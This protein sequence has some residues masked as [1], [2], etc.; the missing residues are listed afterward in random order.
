MK[1]F[2]NKKVKSSNPDIN[3]GLLNADAGLG[4]QPQNRPMSQPSPTPT[5][6]SKDIER[7]KVVPK[8]LHKD[9]KE[10]YD[11]DFC[12]VLPNPEDDQFKEKPIDPKYQPP[13]EILRRLHTAGLETY[14]YYSGDWDEIFIKIRAPLDV[15]RS[16]AKNMELKMLLDS[17]YIK[18]HI[19]NMKEPIGTDENH[20]K[21]SPY[22]FIYASYDD[23]KYNSV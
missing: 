16:H 2:F 9:K 18:R 22:E 12:L 23:S 19:E 15:L 11:W 7:S 10:G 17:N 6:A 1:N 4:M 13:L 14:Q 3:K 21:L 8:R 5:E 20:T